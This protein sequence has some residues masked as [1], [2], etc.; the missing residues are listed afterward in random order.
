MLVHGIRG[1]VSLLQTPRFVGDGALI[2]R[3]ERTLNLVPTWSRLGP[4]LVPPWF[5][6]GTGPN[7]GVHPVPPL[8]LAPFQEEGLTPQPVQETAQRLA[9]FGEAE[10]WTS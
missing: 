3:R 2:S 9:G 6:G 5:P 4:Y 8:G 10:R 7:G 1:P